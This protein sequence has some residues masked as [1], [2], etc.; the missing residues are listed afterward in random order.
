MILISRKDI[1]ANS[2]I[3]LAL[4]ASLR[5]DEIREVARRLGVRRGK[6]VNDTLRNLDESGLLKNVQLSFDLALLNNAVL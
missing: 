5:R 4:V 3:A 2:G 1:T 6:N